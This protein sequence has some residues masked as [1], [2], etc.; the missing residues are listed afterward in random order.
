MTKYNVK[1]SLKMMEIKYLPLLYYLQV[2]LL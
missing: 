1:L 2:A